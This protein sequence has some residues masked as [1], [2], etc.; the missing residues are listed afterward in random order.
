M[1]DLNEHNAGDLLRTLPGHSSRPPAVDIA[2][3]MR[4]GRR[5]RTARRATVAGAFVV[6][7][8]V[9]AGLPAVLL[10]S[11]DDSAPPAGTPT[12]TPAATQ[13]PSGL[14]VIPNAQVP[15]SCRAERLPENGN[16]QTLMTAADPA[17]KIFYGLTDPNGGDQ[18]VVR[19]QDGKLTKVPV[20]GPYPTVSA[21]NDGGLAAGYSDDH[22]RKTA[23]LLRDG[24][25]VD[26]PRPQDIEPV[27]IN[28]HGDVVG[29][30]ISG[31]GARPAVWRDPGAEPEFLPLPEGAVWGE[32]KAIADDGTVV[33]VVSFGAQQ[34]AYA[35]APDGTPRRLAVPEG[36]PVTPADGQNPGPSVVVEWARGEWASG[37]VGKYTDQARPVR[38]NLRTGNV[39]TL[40]G[41]AIP[42][43][44]I[45][46]LGW[47]AGET[48]DGRGML[49]AGGRR[50][51]LPDA[52]GY[53][54]RVPANTPAFVSDD[55]RVVAGQSFDS[56]GAYHA[57]LW[58]C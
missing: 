31:A 57:V 42:G 41:I 10:T 9:A 52:Y 4:E 58:R 17:G 2:R 54:G 14:P 25:I 23:F 13:R 38:W 49:L 36:T 51:P 21:V 5:R 55:G 45:N 1:V 50:I 12:T 37:M 11:R 30:W 53:H 29:H 35:W 33:G 7:A 24:K 43:G 3:A 6:A 8:L 28:S 15:T 34:F 32:P 27:G 26:L 22:G 47:V 46:G 19:W 40:S 20:P 56:H 44:P 16:G 39:D 48:A 18:A